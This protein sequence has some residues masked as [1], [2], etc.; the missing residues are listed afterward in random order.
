METLDQLGF[1][2]TIVLGDSSLLNETPSSIFIEIW[3]L[4]PK[5][6]SSFRSV[7]KA[8]ADEDNDN[9]IESFWL[10]I[11]SVFPSFVYYYLEGLICKQNLG[12][13]AFLKRSID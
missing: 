7:T 8:S 6:A 1:L 5:L 4:L 11:F 3:S 2:I 10:Y 9:V 13:D 12:K